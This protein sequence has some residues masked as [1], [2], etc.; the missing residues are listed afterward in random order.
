[1]A[2]RPWATPAEVKAYTEIKAVKERTDDKL[3]VD[4]S[5]AEKYVIKYT[6]NTF[7]DT[8]YPLIP[9]D[10]K[11]AVILLAENYARSACASS[12]S[13]RGENKSETFDDYSYTAYTS[14]EISEEKGDLDLGYLL[15][16]FKKEKPR[17]NIILRVTKL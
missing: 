12:R 5:R 1:M 9:S 4:I 16:E 14:V 6:N 3:R 13:S 2:S 8:E 7:S 17:G 15:D 11:N 10:V